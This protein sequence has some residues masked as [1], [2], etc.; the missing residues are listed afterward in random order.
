MNPEEII[1]PVV[2]T[3]CTSVSLECESSPSMVSEIAIIVSL[4]SIAPSV[5]ISRLEVLSE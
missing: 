4:K 1:F 2:F 5:M 3:V